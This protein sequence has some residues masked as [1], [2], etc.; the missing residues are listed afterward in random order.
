M[1]VRVNNLGDP[2][3]WLDGVIKSY[4]DWMTH[5][6]V[7]HVCHLMTILTGQVADCTTGDNCDWNFKPVLG[8]DEGWLDKGRLRYRATDILGY[9]V[10]K[11]S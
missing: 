6:Y 9:R 5:H 3:A 4:D 10:E 8:L 1:V 11:V 7:G 2:A